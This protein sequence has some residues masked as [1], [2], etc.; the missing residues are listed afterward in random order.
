MLTKDQAED[1]RDQ[2]LEQI[3]SFPEEKREIAE[4]KILAMTNEELEE[5]LKQN[6]SSP[7]K[8]Q[9]IF[10]LIV[11]G[12][13]SSHKIAEEKD[14]IAVLEINPIAKGHSLII[15]KKHAETTKIPRSAFNLAKKIAEKIKSKLKPI[16]IK[17]TT[18]NIMGHALLEIIPFYKDTDPSK[19]KKAEERELIEVQQVLYFVKSEKKPKKIKIEEKKEEPKQILPKIKSRI[20]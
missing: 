12:K 17:I 8:Q 9:C 19:R 1:I 7:E 2:L 3:K 5:F 4:E 14:S 16:E 10:C 15:P 13:T 11:E 20:P 6:Q 18:S